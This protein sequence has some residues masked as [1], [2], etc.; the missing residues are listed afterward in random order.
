MSDKQ[1]TLADR[2]VEKAKNNPIIASLVVIGAVIAIAVPI[3][4]QLIGIWQHVDQRRDDGVSEDCKIDANFEA[5]VLYSDARVKTMKN[6]SAALGS[7]GYKGRAVNT[8][9]EEFDNPGKSG[10]AWVIYDSCIK[11]NDP[12]LDKILTIMNQNDYSDSD[13]NL[14]LIPH[15]RRDFSAIEISL[16]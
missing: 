8:G 15:S 16:F 12:R 5:D 7:V 9:F 4:E 10:T 1:K 11:K 14:E 2:W 6:I 13:G 3:A